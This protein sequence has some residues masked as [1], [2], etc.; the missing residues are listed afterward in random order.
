MKK[1]FN[2]FILFLSGV[3]FEQEFTPKQLLTKLVND[4]IT[5]DEF[6][7]QQKYADFSFREFAINTETKKSIISSNLV[8]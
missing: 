8:F 1:V 3:G 4:S 5:K 7:F 6:F 2:L